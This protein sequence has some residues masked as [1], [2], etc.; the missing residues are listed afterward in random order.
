MKFR[1]HVAS[2]VIRAVTMLIIMSFLIALGA[3][4]LPD[5]AAH[6]SD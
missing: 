4:Y 1:Q 3:H 6:L 5:S 2:A